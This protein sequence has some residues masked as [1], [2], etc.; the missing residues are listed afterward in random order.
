MTPGFLRVRE[1]APN[2]QEPGLTDIGRQDPEGVRAP[3]D[4]AHQEGERTSAGR[5]LAFGLPAVDLLTLAFVLVFPLLYLPQVYSPYW[6]PRAA[7]FLLVIGPGVVLL[8]LLVRARDAAAVAATAFVGWVAVSASLSHRPAASLLVG[9]VEDRTAVFFAGFAAVWAIGR[10][11]GPRGRAIVG[12][13]LLVALLPATV[14]GIVQLR[15]DLRPEFPASFTDRSTGLFDNPVFFG[16]LMAG[17]VGLTCAWIGRSRRWV[18]W[19]PALALFTWALNSSG[20]RVALAG[21][22]PF[23]AWAL[24]RSS[25]RRALPA[26]AAIAIGFLAA[27]AAPGASDSSSRIEG[28]ITGG[29]SQRIEAWRPV[30]EA[31]AS[32]P[33]FGWG[34]GR[35]DKATGPGLSVEYARV[36]Q[37]DWVFFDAHNLPL[38]LATTVGMG[39]L[40]LASL[41][42]LLAVRGARGPLVAFAGPVAV[43]WLLQPISV[44]TTVLAMLALGAAGPLT[45]TRLSRREARFA[46]TGAIALGGAGAMAAAL[47]LVTTARFADALETGSEQRAASALALMPWS[48]I[49]A[50]VR[51]Q[52]L[53]Q[54]ALLSGLEADKR[55]AAEAAHDTI[56]IDDEGFM[57]W[58]QLG[59]IEGTFGDDQVALDAFDEALRRYPWSESAWNGK[60]F[61]ANKRGDFVAR[62]EALA[63]L[64]QIGS[65]LCAE[66]SKGLLTAEGGGLER[67]PHWPA[68]DGGA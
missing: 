22:C 3:V 34:P 37:P 23:V 32:R 53:T 24:L 54:R 8:G 49:I 12:P 38:E 41:W 35:F 2:T 4:V 28:D 66:R 46:A 47:L 16:A 50:D 63:R 55:S 26:L 42:G 56:D 5:G 67:Q 57:W 36:S 1:R 60:W 18:A 39:G 59:N 7:L 25:W 64:C 29:R 62:D 61:L 58:V 51:A 43:T 52:A 45:P 30:P 31:I 17:A 48:P 40:A 20:S 6:T 21:V 14:L 68:P 65:V 15:V 44:H 33:I 10:S 11:L 19:I 27:M 13:V 9:V